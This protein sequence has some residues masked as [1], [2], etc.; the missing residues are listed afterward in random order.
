MRIVQSGHSLTDTIIA[1]LSDLI[2]SA[3]MRGGKLDKS[4]L[5]GSPMDWR[6]NNPATP[7]IRQ[8]N[9]MSQ[10]ELLVITERAPLSGTLQF[11]D[12]EKWALHWFE[13]AWNNG[14]NGQG[15]RSI[16]YAT[17]VNLDSG[18]DYRNPN[19]D[20]EG[21]IPFR[22]RLPLEQDRWQFILDYVN[23]N[24]P[25]E[26]PPM[27]MIPGPL[28]M[29]LA[30]DEIAAGKAPG[31]TDISDLFADEIH[32]NELGSYLIALAHFAVIHN[33]DP[34]GLMHG[35]ARRGGPTKAQATWMQDVVWRV[36]MQYS[37][38]ASN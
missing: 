9:V 8:P 22:E 11:H 10:Y 34:R 25:A 36:L 24:R 20:I 5:P 19:K 3:S 4:T 12:S 18:P 28:I 30:Y 29:A 16:L 14:R 17:W 23:A 27:V 2:N 37:D 13:H 35:V 31:I 15:A 33:T 32:L 1:P 38:A 26:S 6:W 7:D 21:H